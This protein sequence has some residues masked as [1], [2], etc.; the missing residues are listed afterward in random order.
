[1]SSR[2]VAGQSPH[3]V[4]LPAAIRSATLTLCQTT[5]FIDAQ[6]GSKGL[7]TMAADLYR[8]LQGEARCEA[9]SPQPFPVLAD[10]ALGN[11]IL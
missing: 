11:Q 8:P 9:G 6:A 3:V 7:L 4:F 2:K 5:I 10:Q 1:M